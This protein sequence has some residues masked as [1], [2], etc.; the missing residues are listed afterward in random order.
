[1]PGADEISHDDARLRALTNFVARTGDPSLMAD[2]DAVAA[3]VMTSFNGAGIPFL[4]L[5]GPALASLLYHPGEQ[6][7]YMDVD[8]LVAPATVER[9]SRILADLGFENIVAVQ[10]VDD[11]LGAVPAETWQRERHL[12]GVDLHARLPGCAAAPERAWPRLYGGRQVITVAGMETPVL[13]QAGLALHLAIHAAQHGTDDLKAMG[14]LERGIERWPLADWQAAAELAA[15][16]G[17]TGT[18]AA[19]LRLTAAGK[20]LAAALS[21]P[22]ARELAWEIENRGERPRGTFHLHALRDARTPAE[23]AAVIRKA[24][25]PKPDWIRR[26][27]RWAAGGRLGLAAGYARHMLRA[28]AWAARAWGYRRR[29]RRESAG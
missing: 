19:G 6:R 3:E 13:G 2:V 16:V 17:A 10:G 9:A 28:P 11:S 24:L 12:L 20:A 26:E 23:A 1:M 4:M 21:L 22:D 5:K 7:R 25:F 8:L 29:M 27:Y 14:D 18:L 15:Q